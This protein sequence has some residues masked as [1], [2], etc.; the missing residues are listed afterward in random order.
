MTGRNWEY[1]QLKLVKMNRLN[2]KRALNSLE[3]MPRMPRNSTGLAFPQ[4]GAAQTD[5][6]DRVCRRR[7]RRRR[8]S[9]IDKTEIEVRST[10]CRRRQEEEEEVV[11]VV[12]VEVVDKSGYRE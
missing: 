9:L 1:S 4:L 5:R 6:P 12:V 8:R 3:Q 10:P 7:R 2:H 11:V